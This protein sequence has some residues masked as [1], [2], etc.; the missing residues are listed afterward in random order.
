MDLLSA[1]HD[2]RDG[3]ILTV[4]QANW[5]QSVSLSSMEED[6]KKIVEAELTKAFDEKHTLTPD[7]LKFQYFRINIYP[8]IAACTTCE[9]GELPTAEEAAFQMP[10]KDLSDWYDLSNKFNPAWFE[11]FTLAKKKKKP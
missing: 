3:R 10:N 11:K 2:L 9:G 7:E 8:I 6:A 1:T 5:V 4:S